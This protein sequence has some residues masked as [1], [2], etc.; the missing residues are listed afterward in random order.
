MTPGFC[1][2][3][4]DWSHRTSGRVATQ[5]G[6]HIAYPARMADAGRYP[7]GMSRGYLGSPVGWSSVGLRQDTDGPGRASS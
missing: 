2:S 6:Q 3:D 4:L 5:D 7:L 1:D